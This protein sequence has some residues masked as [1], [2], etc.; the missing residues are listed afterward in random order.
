MF[1]PTRDPIE[2]FLNLYQE[3]QEA[4]IPEPSA[5]TLATANSEGMPAARMVL[6]KGMIRGGF[7]F[8]TNYES[9]KAQNLAQNPKAALVFFWSA[10]A[11]QIRVTGSVIKLTLAES[12]KYFQSRPRLSQ[13]GAWASAQSQE[14]SG[15]E[16]LEEKVRKVEER[17][18]GQDPLPCPP[19]WG[20]YHVIPDTIEFWFGREGRLHERYHYTKE[21]SG[22]KSS[23]RSP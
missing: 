7:S 4:K 6:Y 12:E 11:T 15:M 2:N 9:P 23:M 16:E 22:W 5:M 13:I 10:L 14:V 1:N 3:A 17:F 19:N 8:Y 20:G 18:K 21:K